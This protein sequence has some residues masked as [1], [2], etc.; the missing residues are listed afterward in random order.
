MKYDKKETEEEEETEG[1]GKNKHFP[2]RTSKK[3]LEVFSNVN[4]VLLPMT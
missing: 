3:K 2:K 1:N 4:I